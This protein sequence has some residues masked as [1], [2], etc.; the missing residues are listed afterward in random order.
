MDSKGLFTSIAKSLAQKVFVAIVIC[1]VGIVLAPHNAFAS[2]ATQQGD[3]ATING[4]TVKTYS[5][6]QTNP[7]W[8]TASTNIWSSKQASPGALRAKAQLRVG[9]STPYD[10]TVA[11][12]WAYNKSA[13]VVAGATATHRFTSNPGWGGIQATGTGGIYISGWHDFYAG[14]ATA[15]ID[16]RSASISALKE[17]ASERI[18]SAAGEIYLRAMGESG[19]MGYVKKGE[20]SVTEYMSP[21]EV[22]NFIGETN[23]VVH[24]NLYDEDLKTVID[25]Y[26]V[27]F[28]LC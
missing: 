4:Y 20:E 5:T 16:S 19:K 3:S 27:S 12:D 1:A 21:Q 13:N 26:P 25:T 24:I 23:G 2:S 28:T 7:T 11:T 17:R 9:I 10:L 14:T 22:L 18:D 15:W 6:A 8:F